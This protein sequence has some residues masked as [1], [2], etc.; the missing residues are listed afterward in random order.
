[1]DRSRCASWLLTGIALLLLGSPVAFA[2]EFAT[3]LDSARGAGDA[4]LPV[5]VTFSARWCGWCRKMAATTFPDP[6]LEALDDRVLWVKLDPDEARGLAARLKIR[7]LPHTVMLDAQD[8]LIGTQP[9]YMTAGGLLQFIEETLADPQP[10]ELPPASLIEQLE[11]L[12]SADDPQSVVRLALEEL[13][14]QPLAEREELLQLLR[15]AGNE[16]YPHLAQLLRDEELR[17]RAAAGVV[18]R[19]L[20]QRDLP[21]DPFAATDVQTEQSAAWIKLYCPRQRVR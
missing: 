1:M 21:F 10:V 16:V 11:E 8:R 18:L 2:V 3:S 4:Q 19:Q 9:G 6:Q 7:G 12:Q 14:Q 20:T 17:I 15:D 13:S 5:V